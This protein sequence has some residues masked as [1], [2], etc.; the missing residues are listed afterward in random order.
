MP[1]PNIVFLLSD[2]Q[3]SYSMGCYGNAEVKTPQMD[4]LA[5]D[6]MAFDCHYDTTAICMASR[7]NIMT[8]K[9]EFKNGCNF[10]HGNLVAEHWRNS[11]PI[12]LRK[13]GYRT[14][15]A[16]KIGFTVA[17]R[18]EGK[19]KLPEDDFDKW[20]AG[21]GQTHYDTRKN[22]SMAAYAEKYPHSSRA[23]GAFGAD[24]IAE[25]AAA[26]KPFCL[27]ISFITT[28]SR[29]RSSLIAGSPG[30]TSWKS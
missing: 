9:F 26:K 22:H 4:S 17:E 23:Y 14:A 25:S 5:R 3:C 21:P 15:I 28:T 6:G 30:R 24:F 16:G 27:S 19:G 11:Y 8:G 20:G 7:A 18:P 2:D 13:T 1:K 12:L 29:S 10:E